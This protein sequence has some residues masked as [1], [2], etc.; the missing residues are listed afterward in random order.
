MY[1]NLL[2][3]IDL[4]NPAT[5][6]TVVDNA[7]QLTANNPEAVY[8]VVTIVEPVDDSFISAFLPKNFDKSLINE[9]KNAL[10][11][12]TE[13]H[14]PITAK[15]QHIVAH[16]TIYEEIIRISEEKA[17][18]LIIMLASSKSSVKF[19]NNTRR[20]VKYGTKPMLILK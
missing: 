1:N 3:V 14:F 18:D 13:K 10:H 9:V 4:N 6:K 19:S 5:A 15:V 8:R 20:V 2:L 12:F 16:G 7:L 11:R 17:V